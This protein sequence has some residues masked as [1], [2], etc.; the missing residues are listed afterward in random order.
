MIAVFIAHGAWI[1]GKK[2]F[3]AREP[4]TGRIERVKKRFRQSGVVG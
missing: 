2:P 3:F 1:A 4:A